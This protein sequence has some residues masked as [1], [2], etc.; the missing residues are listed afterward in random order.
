MDEAKGGTR[1]RGD[2]LEQAILDAAWEELSRVG[3]TQMTM[4]SVAKR[5]GTN[6][7]VLYR[8]WS[9]KTELMMTTIKMRLPEIPDEIPDTGSLRDDVFSYLHDRVAPLAALGTQT[10]RGLM[11]E[12]QVWRLMSTALQHHAERTSEGK[13]TQ[14]LRKMLRNAKL[15][16]EIDTDDLPPRIVSLPMDLIKCELI[17]KL[18]PISDAVLAEIVDVIFMPLV[19][20]GQGQAL[21]EDGETA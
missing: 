21:R 6:K 12:P 17:T 14:A 8:R 13:I 7:A 3:Y 4:E 18:E 9:N 11:S 5:A 16:G 20:E 19:L 10:I 15:R 2:T 1:R